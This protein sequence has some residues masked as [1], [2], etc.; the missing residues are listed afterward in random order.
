MTK[1]VTTTK[2]KLAEMVME[3]GQPKA[4]QLPDE[5]LLGNVSMEKAQ[6]LMTKKYGRPVTVF[7]VEPNTTIYE[8]EV[9]KFIE[10]ARPKENQ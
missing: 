8:L 4:K 1:E 3:N 7:A 6:R 9:E 5:I 10:I 2:V